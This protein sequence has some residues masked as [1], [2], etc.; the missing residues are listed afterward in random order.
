MIY[1]IQKTIPNLVAFVVVDGQHE[2]T[3]GACKLL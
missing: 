1:E 2:V 3:A